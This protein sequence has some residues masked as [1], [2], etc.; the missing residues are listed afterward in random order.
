MNLG[1]EVMKEEGG[2]LE[3]AAGEG[4]GSGFEGVG[5]DFSGMG[6]GV[7]RGGGVRVV[8]FF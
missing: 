8:G 5:G 2:W 1:R 7:F 3:F 6:A 4:V